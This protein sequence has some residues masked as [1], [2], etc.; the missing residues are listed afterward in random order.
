MQPM[1]TQSRGFT[2]IELLCVMLILAILASFFI[3][4]IANARSD[5]IRVNVLSQLKT[6]REQIAL[7]KEQ[8]GG[9][10][11][12]LV[13]DWSSMTTP[14]TYDRKAV[15]PYLKATP[16]NPLNNSSI[17]FDGNSGAPAMISCGWV[18]DFAGGTGSGAIWATEADGMLVLSEQP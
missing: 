9:A 12:D 15:G 16:I 1:R 13:N 2:L 17:V 7:Y 6:I 14:G 5:A 8:H 11:P 10:L 3:P 18:Y 4:R